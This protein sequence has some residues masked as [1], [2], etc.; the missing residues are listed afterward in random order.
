[1]AQ[2]Y[3]GESIG[4]ESFGGGGDGVGGV[5]VRSPIVLGDTGKCLEQM[6]RG[7]E[8]SGKEFLS[9]PAGDRGVTRRGAGL[10]AN[11][12]VSYGID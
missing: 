1:M 2:S 9:R 5:G 11:E 3:G 6:I 7:A 10:T 4:D 12:V 8:G